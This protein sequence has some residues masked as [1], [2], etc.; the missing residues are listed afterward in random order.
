MGRGCQLE[1]IRKWWC[2]S[3]QSYILPLMIFKLSAALLVACDLLQRTNQNGTTS[4]IAYSKSLRSRCQM[5][6]LTIK[7]RDWL[8]FPPETAVKVYSFDLMPHQVKAYK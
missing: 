4:C 6:I 3:K 5:N 2:L 7:N 1:W 8:V